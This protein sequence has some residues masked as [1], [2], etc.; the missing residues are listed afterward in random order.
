MWLAAVRDIAIVLLAVESLVIGALMALMLLQMRKLVRLLREEIAPLL[1]SANE[2]VETVHG[3]V[4]FVSQNVVSPIIGT[5]SYLAG[6]VQTL[7][8][9]FVIGRWGRKGRG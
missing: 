9:L 4:D 6:A 5:Q 8:S 1:R 2:T 3:T 7:R